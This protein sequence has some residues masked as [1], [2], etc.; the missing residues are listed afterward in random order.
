MARKND[1]GGQVTQQLFAAFMR[2]PW[3]ARVAVVVL[4]LVAGGI[5]LAVSYY[6]SHHQPRPGEEKPAGEPAPPSGGANP[7]DPEKPA[8]LVNAPPPAADFPAGSKTVVFCVWN[9]ENLFDDKDDHRRHPDGEYDTWFANDPDARRKKYQRLTDALLRLNDGTGPDVIV[10]NEIESR[11]A[12]E[13]LKDTLNAS[14]PT[15]A[16]KYEYVAMKELDAGR[17]I[18]P[19]VISRY[20]LSGEKLHGRRQRILEAHV[21]ANGHDLYVVAAHWTSQLSDKGDK[22]DGGRNKYATTIHDMYSDAIRANPKVDFLVC[23]DFNDTPDSESVY[24]KLHMVGDA[25]LVTPEAKPAK[26]F[27]LLSGKSPNEFG[28]HYYSGKPLIYD[29]VGVSPGL[30]DNAGW[31]YVPDSV[32]VPTDGLIRS[33]TRGRRPW[34]FGSPKDDALGRGYSDHFPV[35]VTLKVA[36]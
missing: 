26:L 5:F 36:P 13:L 27:G 2:L 9:M 14:L 23:G 34:R 15:G 24:N 25:K 32:K 4:V 29:H 21:T 16:A 1:A 35:V 18:A 7:E 11:R 30:F 19:C 8:E 20:P 3:K 28:T 10:G 12:A 6:Q 22:E 31:G 33:G 17:H